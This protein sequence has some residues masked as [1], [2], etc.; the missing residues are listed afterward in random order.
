MK[1]NGIDARLTY[2]TNWSKTFGSGKTM[3]M[4]DRLSN[5]T[6]NLPLSPFFKEAEVQKIIKTVKRYFS[7]G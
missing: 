4:S 1:A 6:C 3:P 2:V 5:S 7:A